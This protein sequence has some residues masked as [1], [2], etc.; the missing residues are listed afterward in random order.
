MSLLGDLIFRIMGDNSGLKTTLK[1]SEKAVDSSAGQ[2]SA[3]MA[4]MGGAVA[5]ATAAFTHFGLEVG[6]EAVGALIE[7]TKSSIESIDSLGDLASKLFTSTEAL[8]S[9]HQA[10]RDAD[11]NIE[12][13]D[14][15][16]RLMTTNL[17]QAATEGGKS[18]EAFT[19]LGLS[20]DDLMKQ[21][22]TAAFGTIAD[23]LNRVDNTTQRAAMG[24]AIFG[25]SYAEMATMI[26][27]GSAGLA[28]A[29]KKAELLGTK[30]SSL[31][32]AQISLVDGAFKDLS[33]AVEGVKN[34][35]AV[36]LAPYITATVQQFMKFTDNG[37]LIR[38]NIIPAI[39]TVV[40]WIEKIGNAF[41][42]AQI[43]WQAFKAGIM[44]IELGSIQLV[45]DIVK[46]FQY[47]QN[48]LQSV[49]EFVGAEYSLVWS[50]LKVGWYGAEKVIV[51]GLQVI[52]DMMADAMRA[53]AKAA[54]VFSSDLEEKISGAAGKIQ[55]GVAEMAKGV[56]KDLGS[57]INEAK[58]KAGELVD[59]GKAIGTA[60]TSKPEGIEWLN[61]K[62]QILSDNI[63]ETTNKIETMMGEAWMGTE[64]KAVLDEM[65]GKVNTTAAAV[66]DATSKKNEGAHQA[67]ASPMGPFLTEEDK[68]QM[69]ERKKLI[70][71]DRKYAESYQKQFIDGENRRMEAQLR[72]NEVYKMSSEERLAIE[73][74]LKKNEDD[75]YAAEQAKIASLDEYAVNDVQRKQ[76]LEE[77]EQVH[78]QNL[79]DIT[80]AGEAA[81][82]KTREYYLNAAYQANSLILGNLATLMQSGSR[83]AF[84]VGKA[85]AMAEAAIN[86]PLAA[87]KAYQA[88][89]GI[90]IV[91]PA[92]GVAAAGAAVA[93]GVM[94]IQKISSTQ[95]G[96]GQSGSAASFSAPSGANSG[97]T[98]NDQA[99]GGGRTVNLSLFGSDNDIVSIGSVRKIMDAIS[100]ESN[101]GYPM[102]VNVA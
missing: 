75:R 91:G 26:D 22:P 89:A 38:D 34:Q 54:G 30:I 61:E 87:I 100:R 58:M 35:L 78:Q 4:M 15:S 69:E 72:S 19:N 79:T 20:V 13:A 67:P 10:A 41:Q 36:G 82:Q 25:K 50:G 93:A 86:V 97:I 102:K 32:S 48:V 2:I 16:L 6:K 56:D 5:G 31:D 9:F 28:E 11:T 12:S 74:N 40:G 65:V 66:A 96:G 83:K 18:A 64:W 88:M 46:G 68:K 63:N 24:A 8:S 14:Q 101:N 59:A 1:D 33:G 80:E 39:Q 23:A 57:A 95:F 84:E 42:I 52:V 81:R 99:S 70:D 90:P 44:M 73:N 17:G 29:S 37:K 60:F 53:M 98:I 43:G 7:F 71:D 55:G 76:M 77:S 21:D 51:T 94:N 27:G 62:E 45:N 3:K 85:A 92:L 47:V 49:G